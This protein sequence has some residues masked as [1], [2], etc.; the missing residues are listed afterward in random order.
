MLTSTDWVLIPKVNCLL[1]SFEDLTNNGE[2]ERAC[3]SEVIP[4]VKYMIHKLGLNDNRGIGTMKTE[5]L[6]QETDR[7]LVA[8]VSAYFTEKRIGRNVDPYMSYKLFK[9]EFVLQQSSEFAYELFKF[10]ICQHSSEFVLQIIQV[11][12]LFYNPIQNLSYK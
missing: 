1:K 12:N 11:W 5:P 9:S 2:R 4:S 3:I 7:E 10:G 8:Q 6:I